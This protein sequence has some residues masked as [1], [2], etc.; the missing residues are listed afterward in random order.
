MREWH[1]I[2]SA[3]LD[4]DLQLGVIEGGEAHSLVFPCRP[5]LSGE[6]LKALAQSYGVTHPTIMRALRKVEVLISVG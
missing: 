5:T 6:T 3:P 2:A 4:H 1:P